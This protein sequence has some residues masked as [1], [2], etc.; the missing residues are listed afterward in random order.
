MSVRKILNTDQMNSHNSIKKP[1]RVSCSTSPCI[2]RPLRPGAARSGCPD[3]ATSRYL[4]GGRCGLKLG[5]SRP[6]G[7]MDVDDDLRVAQPDDVAVCQ[8]PLLHRRVVDG[9]AVGGVEVRQ[10]RDVTVPPDLQVSARH[11]GVRQPELG[12]LAAA[13][14]VG[15]FAQLVG[16]PTAVVELQGDRG[17][18]RRVA[19]LAVAAVAAG[20]RGLAVVV[21]ATRRLGVSAAGGAVGRSG[22]VTVT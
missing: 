15:T 8:L 12:V 7:S 14:D 21:V 2:W 19:A 3:I 5:A 11:T 16:A 6:T 10:Q 22:S 4:D 18:R 13:D 1:A 17:P 20:L 9:G